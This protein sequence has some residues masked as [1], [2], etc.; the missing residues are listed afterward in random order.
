MKKEN[1]H[2]L[3][4]SP[5]LGR[6]RGEAS[7]SRASHLSPHTVQH[8]LYTLADEVA[9]ALARE[10][11]YTIPDV[12]TFTVVQRKARPYADLN[13]PGRQ[14]VSQPY[15]AI[16]FRPAHTLLLSLNALDP[17]SRYKVPGRSPRKRK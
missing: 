10:G 17:D 6:G 14:L 9:H 13:N 3:P 5:L 12:G 7:L 4:E 8:L 1:N 11:R 16:K 2:A 15:T